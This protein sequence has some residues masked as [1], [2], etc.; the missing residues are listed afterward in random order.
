MSY[1]IGCLGSTSTAIATS[2]GT[3]RQTTV[4]TP[5]RKRMQ[6]RKL[7]VVAV[8]NGSNT[9]HYLTTTGNVRQLWHAFT[10]SDEIKTQVVSSTS[11]RAKYARFGA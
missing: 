4:R 8:R 7:V 5:S 10:D 3:H 6:D 11:L 2:V 1:A 9:R